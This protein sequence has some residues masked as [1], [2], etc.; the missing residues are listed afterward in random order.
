MVVLVPIVK[1]MY[2]LVTHIYQAIWSFPCIQLNNF[3]GY[4]LTDE[5]RMHRIGGLLKTR[6]ATGKASGTQTSLSA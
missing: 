6:Q 1:Y 3:Y 5:A 2:Q 4:C